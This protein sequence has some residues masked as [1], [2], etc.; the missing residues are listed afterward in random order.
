VPPGDYQVTARGAS[1]D[2]KAVEAVIE[3]GKTADVGTI[4]VVAGRRLAGVVMANGQPVA[5]ATVYAG[6]QVMGNGT[7]NATQGG[8]GNF[9]GQ[10]TKT[11]T[12][13]PDGSFGLAGFGDGDLA[14]VAEL[15][16]IGRSTPM[17]VSD[18]APNQIQLV[19]ELQPYGSLSG[20]LRP[21]QAVGVTV[22]S[23]TVPGAVYVVESG[24]DGAY[25][26]D[27]LAPDTY[28]VSAT[29]G[30]LRRGLHFY[31]KQVTLPMGGNVTV[32]LSVDAGAV[33]VTA[34]PVATKLGISICWLATTAITAT[35]YRD[36]SLALAAAGPGASQM[37]VARAGDPAAFTA[38]SPGPVSVCVVPL[39]AE[40]GNGQGMG[41]L[42][43][44]AGKLAAFCMPMVVAPSPDT[45]NVQVPVTVP[46][47]LP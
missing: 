15:P 39:P 42:D 14:I 10:G 24:A 22:Q 31:S 16:S 21:P 12:T 8:G 9:G 44:H 46:P 37:T 30:S 35:S 2:T 20:T 6:R 40:L 45:Q 4:T 38:V 11:D 5:G 18:G 32:D 29:L 36:L 26:F 43:R 3:P 33:T 13:G 34:T 23:T 41:Y 7:S 19:L 17:L 25:R 1:F 47:L 27:N 28:K